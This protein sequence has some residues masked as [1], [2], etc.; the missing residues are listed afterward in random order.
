LA[1]SSS[2]QPK[3]HSRVTDKPIHFLG[4]DRRYASGLFVVRLPDVH[5]F[6]GGRLGLDAEQA[7]EVF[8]QDQIQLIGIEARVFDDLADLETERQYRVVG[9]QDQCLRPFYRTQSPTWLAKWESQSLGFRR[10]GQKFV[11]LR[12]SVPRK[13]PSLALSLNRK[14]DAASEPFSCEVRCVCYFGMTSYTKSNGL[15]SR[16]TLTFNC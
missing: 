1:A 8:P 12:I 15:P 3:S 13:A 6:W 9:S 5:G 14:H 11:Q 10:F 4:T 16:I 7:R 2:P